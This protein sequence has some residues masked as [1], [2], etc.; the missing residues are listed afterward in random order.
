MT[1]PQVQ[2]TPAEEPKPDREAAKYRTQLRAAEAKI[3]ELEGN[4]RAMQRAELERVA[5]T[6]DG[7]RLH[8][9]SDIW[10]DDVDFSELV[11]ESGRVDADAVRGVIEAFTE[12]RDYLRADRV[13]GERRGDPSQGHGNERPHGAS[14]ATVFRG[15]N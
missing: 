12:G 7:P 8:Q 4:V 6:G 15:D 10:G 1:E 13:R 14:W 9:A 5:T 11:D 2:E 3:A